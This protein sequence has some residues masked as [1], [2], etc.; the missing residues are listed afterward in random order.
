LFNPAMPDDY[1][2]SVKKALTA[3]QLPFLEKVL[4]GKEYSLGQFSV[5]D[6]IALRCVPR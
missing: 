3:R 4:G 5:A 1:K 6:G 2:A